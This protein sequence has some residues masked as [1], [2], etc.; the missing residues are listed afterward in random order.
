MR[1]SE[2]RLDQLLVNR[3]NDR[4][5]PLENETGAIAELFRTREIHMR[6]LARD[7]VDEGGVYDPP[8]VFENVDRSFTVY[9]GN[10]RVT[11]LKL[12]ADPHRAPSHDLQLFFHE[13]RAEWDGEF[14]QTLSCQ[15]VDNLETVDSI[16]FRRHTGSQGGVGQSTWDDRAKRNFIERT[17]R[18]GRVDVAAE[19]E[20]LL[21]EEQE[22][23]DRRVPRS[24]LNRLLSSEDNRNRV[25]ISVVG[26][27]FR[28]THE[29]PV[30]VRTLARIAH[31]LATGGVV[32]QNV[33][34]N[35][36]KRAYLNRLEAGRMLPGEAHALPANQEPAAPVRRRARPPA[37]AV[38][39]NTF[40]PGNAAALPWRGNQGRARAIWDELNSLP[41]DRYPNAVSALV[42]ILLE[43]AVTS[44]NDTRGIGRD[45]D[46]LERRVRLAVQD[47]EAREIVDHEYTLEIDRM[48]QETELISIRS[49]QRY[50]HSADFAPLPNE[51]RIYWTRLSRL[52]SSCLTH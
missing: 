35:E 28:L 21:A 52:I 46:T 8:L 5:G 45:N 30:V 41:L 6:A 34:D 31:D 26:N 49:M 10:R 44:Y 48:R 17:G 42:R 7:I 40:I 2:I 51:L 1:F 16:L 39:E 20:G 18:G 22:L 29:R 38:V 25:G 47:L 4:H 3:A 43:L 23:P 24:T 13:L 12:L 15:V 19:I 27:T 32:L 50:V 33:W 14:P 37:A 11:C 36:G 9:D